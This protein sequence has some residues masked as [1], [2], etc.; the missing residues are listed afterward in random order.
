[1][2]SKR[3]NPMKTRIISGLALAAIVATALCS[4]P[5]SAKSPSARPGYREAHPIRFEFVYE[6]ARRACP[7]MATITDTAR[8][9][10]FLV[11]V[12]TQVGLTA[13]ETTSLLNH[14]LIYG[15]GLIKGQ[16]I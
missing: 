6:A 1:M 3:N 10:A 4:G 12:R 8:M 16:T 5:L 9:E 2:A 15:D 7:I 14:C 11:K 13:A